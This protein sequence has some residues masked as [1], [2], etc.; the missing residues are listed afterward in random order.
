MIA[1]GFEAVRSDVHFF[2]IR[3]DDDAKIIRHLLEAGIVVRHTR[4][5]AGLCG[6]Y[7]RVA[8]RK[9]EENNILIEALKEAIM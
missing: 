2:L 9:P 4:N 7:I 5:F 3:V 8:T 6:K 1:A